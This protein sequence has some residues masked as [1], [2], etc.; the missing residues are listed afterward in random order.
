MRSGTLARLTRL[1][2]RLSWRVMTLHVLFQ[3]GHQ[4]AREQAVQPPF[5]PE[6]DSGVPDARWPVLQLS[7]ESKTRRQRVNP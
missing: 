4:G 5:Q 6:V 7:A 3:R 2:A 1:W